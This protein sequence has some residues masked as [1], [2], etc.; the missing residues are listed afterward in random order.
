MPF[1]RAF[2]FGALL[3]AAVSLNAL[4]K[5][6]AQ[7]ERERATSTADAVSLKPL[8]L[9]DM[10]GRNDPFMA[11]PLLTNAVA[12][13]VSFDINDLVFAGMIEVDGKSVALFTEQG[14]KTYLLRGNSLYDPQDK[15]VD[16]IRG[17]IVESDTNNDV[18]LVQGEHKLHYT[19][20]RL[21]KRLTA[22]GQP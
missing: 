17:N 8:F 9:F 11:Y 19:Y 6:S 10:R 4:E 16:G 18:V 13:G 20:K 1:F 14:G 12:A 2:F 15:V 7:M 22:D 3:A 21:S 5:A